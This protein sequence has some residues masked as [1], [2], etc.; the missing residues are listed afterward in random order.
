MSPRTQSQYQDIREAKRNLIMNVALEQ[1][2]NNGY[3]GTTINQIARQAGISKGLMY[4]YFASKE[5]LLAEIIRRSVNDVYSYFDVDRDGYLTEDEFEFFIRRVHTM[6]LE[7]KTIWRLFFQ[8]LMQGEVRDH[9]LKSFLGSES[10]LK[11]G[12]DPKNE[13]FVPQ[14]MRIVSEYFE[15][16]KEK[17]GK[18]YDPVLE[19][20]LFLVAIKGFAVTCIY[21]EDDDREINNKTLEKIIHLFK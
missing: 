2:A 6:L 11:S 3:H 8:L 10:L 20:N 5:T 13:L 19:L 12:T 1:F 15:R 7:N 9:F 4:N 16:K 21:S 17:R 14:I 18:E